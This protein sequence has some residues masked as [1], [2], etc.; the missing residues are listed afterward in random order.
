MDEADQIV[1]RKR[2]L[3]I[4]AVHIWNL[5]RILGIPEF[6]KRSPRFSRLKALEQP[7]TTFGRVSSENSKIELIIK[8]CRRMLIFN[9]DDLAIKTMLLNQIFVKTLFEIS[10]L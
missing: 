4:E 6:R 8:F 2:R 7:K 9:D 10:P 1:Q 5:G 3:L